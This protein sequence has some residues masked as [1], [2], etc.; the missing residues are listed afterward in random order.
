MSE[1]ESETG[2]YMTD[3][4]VERVVMQSGFSAIVGIAENVDVESDVSSR[5]SLRY[6]RVLENVL[7]F[8]ALYFRF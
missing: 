7:I 4:Y 3:D 1:S 6:S 8:E 5:C 2:F